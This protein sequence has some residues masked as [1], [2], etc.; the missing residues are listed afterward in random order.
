MNINTNRLNSNNASGV[1]EFPFALVC[2]L[3]L[4]V[5]SWFFSSCS[6]PES[7]AE[8]RSDLQ[9]SR[10]VFLVDTTARDVLDITYK[11]GNSDVDLRLYFEKE[12]ELFLDNQGSLKNAPQ[13]AFNNTRPPVKPG[14]PT[15]TPPAKNLEKD[16]EKVLKM[17][18]DAQELY[19]A[20]NYDGSLDAIDA[21]LAIL[22]TSEAYALK[23]S[24]LF[25][26]G[27]ID[28]AQENWQKAKDL[29]P[30]FVMPTII[31]KD[32]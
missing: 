3:I 5:V 14:D 31:N 7:L 13:V 32:R 17:Y 27:S 10:T 24:V 30:E 2:G 12:F 11:A 25:M 19:Y 20:K 15:S 18:E 4:M 21:S 23:G 9:K 26:L 22:P 6:T 8:K 1:F 16:L 28:G 29:D